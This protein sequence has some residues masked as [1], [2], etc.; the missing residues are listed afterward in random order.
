MQTT[1]KR[2]LLLMA[3]LAALAGCASPPP[4]RVTAEATGNELRILVFRGGTAAR[5]GHNHVLRTGDLRVDWPAAGP[6][7]SFRLDALEIDPQALRE[8]LGPAFASTVDNEARAGTRANL[9]KA[10][11]AAAHP[12]VVVRTLQLLGEGGQ[13]VV[14]AEITLHGA[15][16]R[17]WFVVEIAAKRARGE[18]VIRQ[19]DFG[20]Q[21]FTVLGGLLAVQD[22]LV[23]QFELVEP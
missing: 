14:E 18:V 3:T 15:T 13:R 6:M 7:L 23:V 17:Q 12:E 22:A 5:L 2:R 19:S 10:L 21:P 8:R 11:D 4:A 9:L 16:R 1:P 20:I